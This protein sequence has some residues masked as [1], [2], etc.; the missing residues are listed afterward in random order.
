MGMFTQGRSRLV[1]AGVGAAAAIAAT[2]APAATAD[3]PT[4]TQL[5]ISSDSGMSGAVVDLGE[6]DLSS[7][8]LAG[9]HTATVYTKLD[10]NCPNVFVDPS[11]KAKAGQKYSIGTSFNPTG[12][13][14]VSPANPSGLICSSTT[15]FTITG[16]TGGTTT[17]SFTPMAK[18]RGLQ[19]KL[20]DVPA[21][22]TVVVD[23][24]TT[25]DFCVDNPED[26]SCLPQD[27]RP[28][29]PAVANMLI[30]SQIAYTPDI[31]AACS[32][33]FGAKSWR[34]STISYVAL[35]MP[36]PESVKDDLTQYPTFV[37]WEN[38][39]LDLLSGACGTTF[40]HA[41]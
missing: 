6:I 40:A 30:D 38:K 37:S 35:N 14:G 10:T 13:A 17:L 15:A 7:D 2:I 23:G 29:A 4:A 5:Q 21:T 18:N 1:Y 32:G 25:S 41:S 33:H 8:T 22:V 31:A 28:A 26:P 12:I 9:D 27:S 3:A 20:T 24:G 16:L 36:K 11:D 39:V 19:N 34:G